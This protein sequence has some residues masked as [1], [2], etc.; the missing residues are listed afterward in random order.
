MQQHQG[1]DSPASGK[2][3]TLPVPNPGRVERWELAVNGDSTTARSI[4]PWDAGSAV[5]I[6]ACL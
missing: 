6:G 5:G 2:P 3:F 1:L 4:R